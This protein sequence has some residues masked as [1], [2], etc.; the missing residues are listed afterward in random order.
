MNRPRAVPWF[1]VR[2]FYG[3]LWHLVASAIATQDI[4]SRDWMHP[5]SPAGLTK[6]VART[7]DAAAVE[8]APSVTEAL[9]RDVYID[10]I[11][12]TGDDVDVSRAMAELVVCEYELPS[13]DRSSTCIVPRGDILLFGGDTAY[14]V[15]TSTEIEARLLR[16]WNEVFADRYDG[17]TR[18]LLGIAGNHDWFDGL[19]GFARMFR[20]RSG[21]LAQE[22]P[23]ATPGAEKPIEHFVSWMEAFAMGKH[24]VKRRALPLVGYEPVQRASYFALALAPGID[25]WGVDRQLRQINFQQRRFFWDRRSAA[26]SQSLLL[27]LPDPLFLYLQPSPIGAEMLQALDLDPVYDP[28]LC[29]A[30]DVHHY[31]RWKMGPTVHLVAGGGGA[32]L[33]GARMSRGEAMR[34]PEVEF[35]GAAATR[36]LLSQVPWRV[37]TGRAGIIPHLCLAALFA[38]ALGVGLRAGPG[39]MDAVSVGAAALGAVVCAALAGLRKATFRAVTLLASAAGV[40]MALVP[41]ATHAGFDASLQWLK[42]S[43]SPKMAALLVFGLSIFGG[44]FVFGC[45]L[46]ALA[47][48]GLNHDQAFAALAHPGYKHMVRMRV[49][50]DGSAIDAWVIG[51]VDP[52]GDPTPVLVDQIT[53]TAAPSTRP[54]RMPP[55]PAATAVGSGRPSSLPPQSSS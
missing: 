35:P 38:P 12:D 31:E 24:V 53:F 42:V 10:F 54:S 37:A 27:C 11:A 34:A 33:H 3:H 4:D 20:V 2:S 36:R 30:G 19:D 50:A 47:L 41:T 15:A 5:D 44:A 32:F 7:I 8:G 17:K 25:L 55:P 18:A 40:L 22:R 52:V 26:P 46:A 21:P 39:T 9:G 28:M 48:F 51:L 16:P 49:R 14:P 45:Y 1:G 13:P 6:S 43:P 29:L 23:G